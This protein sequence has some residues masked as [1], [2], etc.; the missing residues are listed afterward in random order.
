MAEFIAGANFSGR[1]AALMAW[2]RAG[3][4]A[5]F[6]GPYA[7]AALSGLASTVADEIAIYRSGEPV[8]PAFAPR[9][10]A[11]CAARKPPTLSGGEQV[12]LALHCFSLSDYA[13]IGI[14]TALEQLDPQNRADALAY[15]SQGAAQNFTA[16]L[17][18]NRLACP[19]GWSPRHLTGPAIDFACDLAAIDPPPCNAP[20]IGVR[21]LSFRYPGGRDIFRDAGFSLE[22][23]QAYRLTGPNGAGKTTLFKLLA[24]VLSPASGGITLDGTAYAPWRGGNRIFAFATQNPDHQWCGATLAEDL[25]RRRAAFARDPNAAM[26]SDERLAA[27]AA[28]LGVRSIDQHL[29]ELPLVARKRL[30]WL[31]P[32]AG[33]MPWV[34]FDEPTLGQDQATRRA[35]AEIIGRLTRGGYGVLFVTHDDEFASLIAHRALR[36]ADGTVR[37]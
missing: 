10:F 35:L 7:E 2:L 4:P 32:L 24:G 19:A 8:R 5:F 26:P 28:R 13:A 31:W 6:V 3:A 9:D 11:S 21:Q 36:L 12:L 34:M 30:S 29:Y 25:A 20:V 1:S 27:L 16:A 33:A 22:P 37:L 18:D 17:I 14:D 23:G 15:L